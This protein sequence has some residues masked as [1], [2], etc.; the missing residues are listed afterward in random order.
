MMPE[1]GHLLV[2]L[3][4]HL[5]TPRPVADKL[6][7]MISC[8]PSRPNN[9]DSPLPPLS[10]MPHTALWFHDSNDEGA[11]ILNGIYCSKPTS[12]V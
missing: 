10:L 8:L 11:V 9:D 6:P 5:S 2:A 3:G 1:I 12:R 4:P 7:D